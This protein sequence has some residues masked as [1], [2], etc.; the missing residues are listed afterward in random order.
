M[1]QKLTWEEE[2]YPDGKVVMGKI[3]NANR[4]KCDGI[5]AQY[6]SMG[7][8]TEDQKLP[9]DLKDEVHETLT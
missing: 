9:T 2:I 6:A 1:S 5:V 4:Q 8:V 7:N 3:C